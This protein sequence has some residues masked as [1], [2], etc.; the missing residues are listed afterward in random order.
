MESAGL[1][2]DSKL[3]EAEAELAEKEKQLSAQF[4]KQEY[5][6]KMD[7]EEAEYAKR[8]AAAQQKK[9]ELR[10]VKV[11]AQIDE[12]K[13]KRKA[14][15]AEK[16]QHNSVRALPERTMGGDEDEDQEE[17]DEVVPERFTAGGGTWIVTAG[18]RELGH[19][20][21]EYVTV[22]DGPAVDA[23]V[24]EYKV[25]R[26]AIESVGVVTNELEQEWIKLAP[27]SRGY[28]LLT[29]PDP[30]FSDS[31]GLQGGGDIRTLERA[32]YRV[33]CNEYSQQHWQEHLDEL[34]KL[35]SLHGHTLLYAT[36]APQLDA[37]AQG[38][39]GA[40]KTVLLEWVHVQRELHRDGLLPAECAAALD[41]EGFEWDDKPWLF[42][43]DKAVVVAQQARRRQK[44]AM[45][46]KVAQSQS[47]NAAKEKLQELEDR[48]Q[49]PKEV[50]NV[51]EE[52]VMI[53]DETSSNPLLE[54][55]SS[56]VFANGT[57]APQPS[58]PVQ[59][60]E[61]E[62]RKKREEFVKSRMLKTFGLR[63]VLDSHLDSQTSA[64]HDTRGRPV[65]AARDSLL[66]REAERRL[67]S[68]EL[69]LA[70]EKGGTDA[71]VR[72]AGRDHQLHADDLCVARESGADE[73]RGVAP[74]MGRPASLL[75]PD[76]R[77][78][79]G[80]SVSG[81]RNGS[82]ASG[83]RA[84]MGKIHEESKV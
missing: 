63:Q 61:E 75:G 13:A 2:D 74:T 9:E 31:H 29:S 71:T 44:E 38:D 20:K 84:W 42:E 24:L 17:S 11:Q 70:G 15:K 34:L 27:P 43:Q 19:K 46:L 55:V 22:R 30:V 4:K 76:E 36:F 56:L 14:E 1:L 65:A 51:E 59:D 57:T 21:R 23:R 80:G 68:I 62:N 3:A 67:H 52:Q 50:E 25:C 58:E 77:S 26:E 48:F 16:E 45:A 78:T 28:V 82:L 18:P 12:I 81:G 35:K 66:K 6:K 33:G 49:L 54:V 60:Q 8:R 40:R 83:P 41:A 73:D 32:K 39:L 10:Q 7:A 69:R 37:D 79:T 47:L 53:V 5:D 64:E 72:A